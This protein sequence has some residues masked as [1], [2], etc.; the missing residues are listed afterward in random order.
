M[1][2]RAVS[3]AGTCIDEGK[4]HVKRQISGMLAIAATATVAGL[5][6]SGTPAQAGT[7]T[8]TQAGTQAVKYH[9]PYSSKGTCEYWRYA[10]AAAG[11]RV[12][13][14]CWDD[15]GWYFRSW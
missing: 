14:R 1:K 2:L 13:P 9:G 15:Q 11:V 4:Y 8:G 10:M 12:D 7:P 6:L 5:T 3:V